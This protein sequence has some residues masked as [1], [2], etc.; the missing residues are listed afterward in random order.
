MVIRI[1]LVNDYEV[2]VRGLATMLRSYRERVHV[3]ELDLNTSVAEDVDI[4]MY[5]TFANPR[6]DREEIQS[7]AADPRVGKVAVY[8][9]NLDPGLITAALSDGASGYLSKAL[10][11]KDLVEALEAIHRGT[12][13]R[14][15][16]SEGRVS[17]VIGGDWPGREEGLTAREAEILA[18]IT[19]GLS[20]Q[21]IAERTYLSLNSIK[22]HIRSC[23]RRIGVSTRTNA[24]LWGIEHGFRPDRPSRRS[25][26]EDF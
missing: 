26:D 19:Q 3:V 14:P 8:T 4:A 5:D 11:A 6:G 25:A 13:V 10:P 21:E 22:T 12:V 2:V 9:W 24:V 17:A 1:A 7:L 15:D 23:Y 18:L 16:Q 20:N